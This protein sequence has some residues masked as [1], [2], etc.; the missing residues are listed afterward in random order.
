MQGAWRYERRQHKFIEVLT[1]FVV[2]ANKG[3]GN[4]CGSFCLWRSWLGFHMRLVTVPSWSTCLAKACQSFS[5]RKFLMLPGKPPSERTKRSCWQPIKSSSEL[6]PDMAWCYQDVS[7]ISLPSGS[8]NI[9][10]G[11]EK[12]EHQRPWIMVNACECHDKTSSDA[13]IRPKDLQIVQ[14]EQA[15]QMANHV[16]LGKNA[17]ELHLWNDIK[18]L[19]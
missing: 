1:A 19:G 15:V 5:V 6:Q 8:S 13:R 14:L 7:R 2:L 16:L 3:N 17:C 4:R 9:S 11:P 18:W 12:T 10:A